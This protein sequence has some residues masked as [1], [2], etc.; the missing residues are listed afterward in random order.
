MRRST[1]ILSIALALL[2]ASAFA[3]AVEGGRWWTLEEVSIGP[4]STTQCFG[5]D[6]AKTGFE[7]M[8][9]GG[10]WIRWGAATYA[11]GLAAAFV[12]ITL[13]AALASRRTGRLA[14]K[15]SIS[16]GA[17][18]VAVAGIFIYT[19]PPLPGMVMGRGIWMYGGGA[20]LAI[21]AALVALRGGRQTA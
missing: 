12:L 11:A 5:G 10:P 16:A 20:A 13:A 3:I 7:W 19:F 6:C 8:G 21:A 14:A 18:A 2:G 17:T 9:P 1:R 4:V 15:V